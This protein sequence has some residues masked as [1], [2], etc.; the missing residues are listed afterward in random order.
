[1][2]EK[3]YS[4]ADIADWRPEDDKFWESTGKKIAY[5]NLWI[6]IPNLL[7]RFCGVG[8]VG[9][10]HGADAEPGLSLHQG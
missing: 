10:H 7:V 1:M 5:R 9:H 8:Y 2:S 4:S 6:S 3:T